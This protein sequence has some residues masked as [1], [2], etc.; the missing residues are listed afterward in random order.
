MAKKAEPSWA[1]LRRKS[2][3]LRKAAGDLIK[4]AQQLSSRTNADAIGG[5]AM[6]S[7]ELE[8]WNKAAQL[9]GPGAEDLLAS[10]K[11]K[12]S[13]QSETFDAV[14]ARA[15]RDSGLR[16]FGESGLMVIEGFIHVETDTKKGSVK[17]NGIPLDD[18]NPDGVLKTVR[19]ELAK[20]R[21]VVTPAQKFLELLLRAYQDELQD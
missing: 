12:S 13:E 15:L 9:L 1:S 17:I 14:L 10:L 18:L 6:I 21:N 11:Q 19:S 3:V 8:A 4:E 7:A 2:S 5:Y 20:L 16:V